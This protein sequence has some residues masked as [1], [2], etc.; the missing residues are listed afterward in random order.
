LGIGVKKFPC[1]K[2]KL[3]LAYDEQAGLIDIFEET[4]VQ[5]SVIGALV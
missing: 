2:I 1:L 3:S 4:P 5:V